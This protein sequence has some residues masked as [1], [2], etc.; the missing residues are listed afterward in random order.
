MSLYG[1]KVTVDSNFPGIDNF[2]FL[3]KFQIAEGPQ[4]NAPLLCEDTG[5]LQAEDTLPIYVGT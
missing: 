3:D 5:P 4:A 2:V 1:D